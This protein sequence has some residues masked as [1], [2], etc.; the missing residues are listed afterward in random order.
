MVR[1]IKHWN[2]LSGQFYNIASKA[3]MVGQ[4]GT[5]VQVHLKHINVCAKS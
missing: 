1:M 5:S 3:F 2:K 4:A